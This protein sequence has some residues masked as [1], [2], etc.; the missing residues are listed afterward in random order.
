MTDPPVRHVDR[1]A[2]LDLCVARLVF[3]YVKA[4]AN[5]RNNGTVHGALN[6]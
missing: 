5:Y 2:A 4:A 1:H 3:G 6:D